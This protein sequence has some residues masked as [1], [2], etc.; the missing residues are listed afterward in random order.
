MKVTGSVLALV[1]TVLPLT[2][3]AFCTFRLK[4]TGSSNPDINNRYVQVLDDVVTIGTPFTNVTLTFGSGSGPST[5]QGTEVP[6][7]AIG[8]L[9]LSGGSIGV[10]R[11]AFVDQVPAGV[12]I[13]LFCIALDLLLTNGDRHVSWT[14]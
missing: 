8:N 5:I 2:A 7:A 9:A 3:N 1:S 10:D 4:V 6:G 14:G 12:S 13:N 11:L